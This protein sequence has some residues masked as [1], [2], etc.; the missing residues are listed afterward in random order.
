M[1]AKVA[2][3]VKLNIVFKPTVRLNILSKLKSVIPTLNHS[4]VVYKINCQDYKEFYIG[5]TTRRLHK[6]M[7]EHMK[8]KYCAVYK[9]SET[10][11]G[12]DKMKIRLQIKETL[13]IS[14]YSANKSLNVNIDSF[15]CKLW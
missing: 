11:H 3:W 2:P 4:N 8:R 1:L 5:L 6:R 7:K 14:Q 9:H 15:E 12:Y 13:Q 10:G